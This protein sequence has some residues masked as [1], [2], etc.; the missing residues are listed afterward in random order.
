[1]LGISEKRGTLLP[2][3]TLPG[4]S[5]QACRSRINQQNASRRAAEKRVE[6][7]QL[8]LDRVVNVLKELG[9]SY[10]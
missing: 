3:L 9:F 7:A 4:M 8:N 1:M 10:S 5:S 2:M 6:L